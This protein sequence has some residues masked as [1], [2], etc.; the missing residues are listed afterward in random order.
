[1]VS[2]RELGEVMSRVF[3]PT[4]CFQ[5]I[6]VPSFGT[7]EQIRLDIVKFGNEVGEFLFLQLPERLKQVIKRQRTTLLEGN[8]S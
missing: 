8:I 6:Q 4:F 5:K 3:D 1:M 7:L 2:N